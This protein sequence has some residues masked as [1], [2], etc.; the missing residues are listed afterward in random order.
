M[1]QSEE[2]VEKEGNGD[3]SCE[4]SDNYQ[5]HD[6]LTGPYEDKKLVSSIMGP[7]EEKRI[8]A[9]SEEFNKFL[10]EALQNSEEPDK[11]LAE[12][13]SEIRS[14]AESS[15][16]RSYNEDNLIRETVFKL[17]KIQAEEESLLQ[18][19]IHLAKQLDQNDRNSIKRIRDYFEAFNYE[20]A[21]RSNDKNKLFDKILFKDDQM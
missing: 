7:I 6:H 20:L 18:N 5:V 17:K 19:F 3:S 12:D 16:E 21:I 2:I 8:Q 9:A 4:S 13:Q 11:L 15:V 10:K 1:N 14:K